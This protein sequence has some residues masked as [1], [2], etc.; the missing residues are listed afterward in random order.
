MQEFL[1]GV[2]RAADEFSRKPFHPWIEGSDS[3]RCEPTRTR[4]LVV[5]DDRL[6]ADTTAEILCGAG[7]DAKSVY[8]GWAALEMARSFRPDVLLTDVMMPQ[9]NGIELA[10]VFA[11]TLPATKALLFSGQAGIS[12]V[13]EQGRNQGYEFPLI[14]K[15]I[16]PIKLIETLRQHNPRNE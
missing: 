5:D 9:M 13:L 4:V 7:F 6:V 16:H 2:I 12:V 15:P 8:D 11:K 14:A 1:E 3:T 10:M